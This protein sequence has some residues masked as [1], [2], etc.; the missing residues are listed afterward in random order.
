MLGGTLENGEYGE[1]WPSEF[2]KLVEEGG[3]PRY[4]SNAWLGPEPLSGFWPPFDGPSRGI[5][6]GGPYDIM[7]GGQNGIPAG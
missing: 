6:P 7:P 5:A 2:A 3:F 1:Y 4:G